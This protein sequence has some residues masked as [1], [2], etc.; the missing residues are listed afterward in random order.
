MRRLLLST[1]VLSALALSGCNGDSYEED[2]NKADPVK[3]YA[4]VSFDPANGVVPLP[5][6]LLLLGT[7][8][9]TLQ[10]PAEVAGA[11][12][13]DPEAALGALDG[14]GTTQPIQ[15]DI[16]LLDGVTIDAASA[17]EPG[18][19]RLFAV[20]LG[21]QLSPDAEC[22][23]APSLSIC[24]MGEELIWGVDFI[25]TVKGDTVIAQPLKPLAATQGYLYATTSQLLDSEG[26]SLEASE[27][28]KQL[29]LDI[30]TKPLPEGTSRDLQAL[31]NNYLGALASGHGIDPDIITYTGVFTTQS[32]FDVLETTKQLLASPAPEHAP[33]EPNWSQLPS[34]SGRTA[35]QILGLQPEMGLPYLLADATDVWSA[36]L[37]LPYYLTT[38]TP[39]NPTISS[40]WNALGDS[41]VAVLQALQAGTL[42]LEKFSEQ[43]V[44]CGRDPVAAVSDPAEIVGCTINLDDGTPSDPARHL[45][46]FNPVPAPKGTQRVPVQITLPNPGKLALLGIDLSM[47]ASGWPLSMALHGLAGTK[48]TTLA[49]VGSMTAN[50]LATIAIDLPLHGA[51][52]F[53]F[54]G[55]GVYEISATDPSLGPAFA[56]GSGLV[57]VNIGSG[58]TTRDNYRQAVI[59]NLALRA[60]VTGLVAGQLEAG[61]PPLFDLKKVT[62]QGLS[63]GAITGSKV[64]VYANTPIDGVPAG[65]NP[66]TLQASSLAA[67]AGGL[68]GTFA[69]SP[70]F[71]PA[72]IDNLVGVIAEEAGIAKPEPGTPEYQAL[73]A[74]AEAELVPPLMFSIQTQ[75]EPV[76]PI[77]HG[78]ALAAT[79]SKIH[80]IEVVGDGAGNLPDQTLPPVIEGAPLSGGEP[81]IAAMGLGCIDSSVQGEAVSG[82]VRF[83]KGHHSSLLSPKEIPGVT[84][85]SA[86]VATAE[87]QSQVAAFAA[88]NGTALPVSNSALVKPCS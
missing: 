67:P 51:R 50:G 88:S 21:G 36:E 55:D 39:T 82:V 69:G 30:N 65:M 9:G 76:D 7:P 2:N 16:D 62:L 44:A 70:A 28:Y 33:F 20:T 53:D 24:K 79:G 61:Q 54:N 6:D 17:S 3:R 72:L 41:P 77:N 84:D 37:T 78:A 87:M 52:G 56:N 4:R 60:A 42:T 27:T 8:D 57:F 11:P 5:N 49:N 31:T 18:A 80:L 32:V 45:T 29:K 40:T 75:I 66:F 81:L 68:A 12:Y 59:D 13:T 71:K 85:G 86:A 46:R 83:L 64:T 43:M 35:A 34:P 14:W 26:R 63:Q 74:Q 19:V 73:A 25:T 15:L 58:L 47:P 22:A 48:E 10:I 38:P 23:A 1:A